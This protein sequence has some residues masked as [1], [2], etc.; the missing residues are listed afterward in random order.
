M[1]KD[2][3]H[4]SPH[5][6]ISSIYPNTQQQLGSTAHQAKALSDY[7]SHENSEDE[8]FTMAGGL[9]AMKSLPHKPAISDPLNS[10]TEHLLMQSCHNETSSF[11]SKHHRQRKEQDLHEQYSEALRVAEEDRHA[12]KVVIQPSE[13]EVL[14][15]ST[16]GSNR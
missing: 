16:A 7:T 13:E 8:D 6:A 3:I 12:K 4:A 10:L 5:E 11:I 9:K 15:Q 2:E 1:Y 14:E